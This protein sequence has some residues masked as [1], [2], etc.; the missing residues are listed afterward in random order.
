MLSTEQPPP[1][2]YRYAAYATRIRTI[3]LSAHR[4]VAYASDVGESFRPVAHPWLVRGAYVLSTA[5]VMG[6]VAVVGWR[7]RG[8]NMDM[9]ELAK[10][11]RELGWGMHKREQEGGGSTAMNIGGA[12]ARDR[13]SG[14]V[15]HGHSETGDVSIT[16]PVSTSTSAPSALSARNPISLA[17]DFRTIM[18][19]RAVF[20]ALA[21]L[22]LPALT[23]H[24]VVR[25]SGR[26]LRRLPGTTVRTVVPVGV[27]L[28]CTFQICSSVVMV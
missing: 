5:Y 1:T 4:Y 28:P 12:Q 14:Q 11:G 27:S 7:A 2:P 6:D 13:G 21:S 25:Y 24:T 26:A 20:Q 22:I 17:D 19:E 9:L 18:A 16:A 23:V 3:L 10:K 8:Q 15:Q